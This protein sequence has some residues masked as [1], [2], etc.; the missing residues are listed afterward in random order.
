MDLTREQIKKSQNSIVEGTLLGS[1]NVPTTA[2]Y[3]F[4]NQYPDG[5]VISHPECSFEVCNNSD[6][7][8]STEF[9]INTIK[10][11][12]RGTRWLV[13]T[14]LNLVSRIAEEFKPERKSYT[15][16][17][18]NS[19]YVLN[20]GSYRSPAPCLDVR[21]SGEWKSSKPD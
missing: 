10:K 14:E 3:S 6:Y 12:K 17:V 4:R 18:S 8:G 20:Y 1:P 5:L 13:G 7:V 19:M 2:Y 16:Y 11:A 15:V 21:E 9:I